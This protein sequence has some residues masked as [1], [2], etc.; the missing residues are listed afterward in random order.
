MFYTNHLMLQI[1]KLSP[2]EAKVHT[3][4]KVMKLSVALELQQESPDSHSRRD[5]HSEQGPS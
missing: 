3:G 1:G 2:R 4:P 5:T